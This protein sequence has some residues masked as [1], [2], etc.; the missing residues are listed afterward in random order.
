MREGKISEAQ[1]SRD[2]ER[3]GGERGKLLKA[4]AH[5]L[6][7]PCQVKEEEAMN[8]K[9]EV[10]GSCACMGVCV[11]VGERER[12]RERAP[13]RKRGKPTDRHTDRKTDRQK[14]SR[15]RKRG[16]LGNGR[17]GCICHSC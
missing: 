4:G 17:S 12:E 2:T 7:L 11:C 1:G 14:Q 13:G 9:P 15:S 6:R 8:I 5:L 16:R 3:R 10:C